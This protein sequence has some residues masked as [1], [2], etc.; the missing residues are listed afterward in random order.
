M[1]GTS[2]AGSVTHVLRQCVTYVLRIFCYLCPRTVHLEQAVN[3]PLN[4]FADLPIVDL[5]PGPQQ[6]DVSRIAGSLN[7]IQQAQDHGAISIL[8]TFHVEGR[9]SGVDDTMQS[10]Q[11]L[12]GIG[13]LLDLP[14]SVGVDKEGK[15]VVIFKR[16]IAVQDGPVNPGH[17]IFDRQPHVMAVDWAL[18]QTKLKH[19]LFA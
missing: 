13:F 10:L 12:G 17:D 14:S 6:W 3:H 4:S 5:L 18:V 19:S 15:P 11:K 9:G 16:Q 7:L 8:E 1:A 2:W